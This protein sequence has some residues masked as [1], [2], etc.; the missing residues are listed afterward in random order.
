MKTEKLRG[1]REGKK[2]WDKEEEDRVWLC[3]GVGTHGEDRVD[4]VESLGVVK[5]HLK[6]DANR[7][8]GRT[9]SRRRH[10]LRG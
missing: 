1:T 5:V 4:I 6:G 10:D 9:R 3:E 8:K 2:V 7:E